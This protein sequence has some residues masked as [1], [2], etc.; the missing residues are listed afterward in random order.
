[1][2]TQEVNSV[3]A[4]TCIEKQMLVLEQ[5]EGQKSTLLCI[6]TTYFHMKHQYI[7][8]LLKLVPLKRARA[9]TGNAMCRF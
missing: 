4:Q 9:E 6:H 7:M 2:S 5:L 1:M 8:K 3:S